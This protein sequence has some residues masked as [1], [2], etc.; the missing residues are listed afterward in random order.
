[1]CY[2]F[3]RQLD[4]CFP[5]WRWIHWS[6]ADA[7]LVCSLA[8]IFG[9]REIATLGCFFVLIWTCY[10]LG[11]VNELYSR[12]RFKPDKQLYGWP[13]GGDKKVISESKV[14]DNPP[15]YKVD[16]DVDHHA[17]K[18]ISQD[19]WEGDR[20]IWDDD[21][22]VF[23]NSRE[24]IESQR[25]DNY[26][27][28]MLPHAI[29]WVPGMTPWVIMSVQYFRHR[30]ELRDMLGDERAE[31]EDYRIVLFFGCAILSGS[32]ALVQIIFQYLPPAHYW[33][34]ELLAILLNL[35]LKSFFAIIVLYNLI[36]GD[37]DTEMVLQ[38]YQL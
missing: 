31:Y 28:R 37:T 1:M 10:I 27:R 21:L 32:K 13:V 24:L 16:Y 34:S 23:E 4:D 35:A 9:I 22:K 29:G 8:L 6:V 25:I 7:L 15:L 33:V 20:P 17:L 3:A 30:L 38:R 5:W 2:I 26:F 14:K 19:A 11:F 12:P 36:G 18:L